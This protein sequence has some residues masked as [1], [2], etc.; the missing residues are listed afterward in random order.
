MKLF[1]S[2]QIRK[3]DELTLR[4]G[5][6][7]R[8]F[9]LMENVACTITQWLMERYPDLNT[10]FNLFAGPGNNGGDTLAVARL[11]HKRGYPIKMYCYGDFSKA[12]PDRNENLI[13]LKGI[14]II[15]ITSAHVL[16][17]LQ[18][19][20][21]IIDG[22]FGSGLN[23][24]LEGI[25]Y[26][27]V[28]YLN[29]QQLEIISIDLPSGLPSD[30]FFESSSPKSII[31]AQITL[32]LEMP[33][34]G[35]LLP[36]HQI[37]VGEMYCLKIGL[38]Q[39]VMQN[40]ETPYH[41][42]TLDMVRPLIKSRP[43]IAHKGIF[44]HALLIAGAKGMAGAAL[45]AGKATLRSGAGLL[46]II[47]PCK[48]RIILQTSLP[49]AMV[50]CDTNEDY[51]STPTRIDTFKAIAIGPGIQQHPSTETALLKQIEICNH[52]IIIDADAINLLAKHPEALSS[53]PKGSI[54]T[55]HI[56][57]FNRLIS[58]EDNHFKRI[59]EASKWC[60][61]N[62]LYILLKG[63]Y[64]TIITPEGNFYF[65]S[66]G[67]PGMATAGSGDVLTG[68]LLGLLAQGYTPLETCLIG[69][70]CHGWAGDEAAL[71]KG[72]IALIAS[73]II[74]ALPMTWRKITQKV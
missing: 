19:D 56:G 1:S 8:S 60:Q 6:F 62:E 61:K 25:A 42:I 11:L 71:E 7:S 2:D 41:Y 49:E 54:L 67:N 16:S 22:L 57:E 72:E 68:M 37:Y 66:T 39:Q 17:T 24:P 5:H 20:G 48:N 18:L 47:A 29:A 12:S 14:N 43:K 30:G 9:D 73:D 65:N 34:L 13:H 3:I 26:E 64:S 21:I 50:I 23:R 33:K 36:E 44:G 35:L 58:T 15:Y 28:E 55:P 31:K 45:L 63:A 38:S 59:Q 46:S 32:T 40:T 69:V 10:K 70:F 74:N 53:L 27:I 52:P 51:F 4:E